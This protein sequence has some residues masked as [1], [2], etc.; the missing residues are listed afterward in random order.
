V[1]LAMRGHPDRFNLS[2]MV[3]RYWWVVV[4]LW[5]VWSAWLACSLAR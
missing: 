5:L 3:L 2:A 4:G 1:E